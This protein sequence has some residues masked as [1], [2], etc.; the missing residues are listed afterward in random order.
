MFLDSRRED[1]RFWTESPLNFRFSFVTVV[2]KYLNSSTFSS[3]LIL[4]SNNNL[5]FL[6]L[7]SVG[8]KFWFTLDIA[9]KPEFLVH[10]QECKTVL[11]LHKRLCCYSSIASYK[12]Q[13]VVKNILPIGVL[14]RICSQ[15]KV[16]SISP[17]IWKKLNNSV[18]SLR[19][20]C[21]TAC[22]A[23][24]AWEF[25]YDLSAVGGIYQLH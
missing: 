20:L 21:F 3:A 5:I 13:W 7:L 6:R 16:S 17:K 24:H 2:P 4:N 25:V 10:V 14:W 12:T 11:F 18:D 8:G 15:N 19:A 1:K 22:S 9:V 23:V